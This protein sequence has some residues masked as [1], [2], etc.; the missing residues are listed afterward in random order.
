MG[1]GDDITAPTMKRVLIGSAG[2]YERLRL[3]EEPDPEPRGA[4]EVLVRVEAIGVNYADCPVPMGLYESAK[5]YVGWPITPGF[6]VSGTLADGERVM[7]LT[8]FG[9]YATHVVVPQHQVF[10][11]PDG[12]TFAEAAAFPVV[13]VTAYYALFEL[14]R[15]RA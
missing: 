13:H 8:R 14:C 6:E 15:L 5:T 11:I 12:F 7:A 2:G 3:V 4:D 9:G 1:R 10:P